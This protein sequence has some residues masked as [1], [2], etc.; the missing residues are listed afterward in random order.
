MPNEA[1]G[2]FAEMCGE[3]L[4][5]PRW[6]SFSDLPGHDQPVLYASHAVVSRG[7]AICLESLRYPV[8]GSRQYDNTLL[9]GH[10]DT[11]GNGMRDTI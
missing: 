2:A 7:D 11:I 5:L 1:S 6:T 10:L 9:H 4:S 3:R 8:D